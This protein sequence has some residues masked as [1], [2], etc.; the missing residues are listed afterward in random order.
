MR[1]KVNRNLA[2]AFLAVSI[3]LMLQLM[4]FRTKYDKVEVQKALESCLEEVES[5]CKGLWEYATT[6]ERENS[7]L[8]HDLKACENESR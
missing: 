7:K 3:V 5:N 8:S 1:G 2:L 4:T 6:L